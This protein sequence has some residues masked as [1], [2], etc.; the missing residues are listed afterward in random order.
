MSADFH[1]AQGWLSWLRA[2]LTILMMGLVSW[3]LAAHASNYG[4]PRDAGKHCDSL[5]TS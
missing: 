5:L 3:P 1:S 4:A 2:V